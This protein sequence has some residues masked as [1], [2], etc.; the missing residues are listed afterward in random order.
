MGLFGRK[1]NAPPFD[2][3]AKPFVLWLA[4]EEFGYKHAT[5]SSAVDQDLTVTGDDGDDFVL[6]IVDRY[7]EWVR[8]WPWERFICFNEGVSML[9]PYAALWNFLRLPWSDTAFPQKPELERLELGHIA[10]VLER[11][12]W[13]DP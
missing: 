1:A 4:R 6:Q 8:E 11:G 10:K 12:E 9:A 7:G 3:G 13:I 5:L 2:E